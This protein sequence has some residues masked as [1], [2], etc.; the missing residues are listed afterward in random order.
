[1]PAKGNPRP[2]VVDASTLR[3]APPASSDE[4]FTSDFPS[5]TA[6]V[7]PSSDDASLLQFTEEPVLPSIDNV[8]LDLLISEASEL[9]GLTVNNTH[10]DYGPTDELG[11]VAMIPRGHANYVALKQTTDCLCQAEEG[12]GAFDLQR[13]H[14]PSGLDGGGSG[15]IDQLD[16]A[17]GMINMQWRSVVRS[18]IA[19]LERELTSAR[20]RKEEPNHPHTDPPDVAAMVKRIQ[21]QKDSLKRAT[22]TLNDELDRRW[23]RGPT[24]NT[25]PAY[26]VNPNNQHLSPKTDDASMRFQSKDAAAAAAASTASAAGTA[27]STTDSKSTFSPVTDASCGATLYKAWEQIKILEEET[28]KL[29]EDLR[30]CRSEPDK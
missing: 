17:N 4:S 22:S 1:M 10:R 11:R 7:N 29:R 19:K 18:R 25:K 9:L 21:T 23:S 15:C 14:A 13:D 6:S 2:S 8:S 16:G 3:G 26:T 20:R 30:K 27:A 12:R 28:D 24:I 5:R